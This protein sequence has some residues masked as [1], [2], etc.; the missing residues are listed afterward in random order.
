MKD[1]FQSSIMVFC[2]GHRSAYHCETRSISEKFPCESVGA[3]EDIVCEELVYLRPAC[4]HVCN[5]SM[6]R[7]TLTQ[8]ENSASGNIFYLSRADAGNR[9]L[10]LWCISRFAPILIPFLAP[11]NRRLLI[12]TTCSCVCSR[13]RSSRIR[14]SSGLQPTFM[15]Q[16]NVQALKSMSEVQ[17]SSTRHV[18]VCS[19][20]NIE[21]V[22]VYV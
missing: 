21:I 10:H 17:K 16:C 4:L 3:Q 11:Q 1:V 12:P 20:L 14:D 8:K 9:K 2:T 18:E 5:G 7:C 6:N 22:T 19:L 15:P 13:S